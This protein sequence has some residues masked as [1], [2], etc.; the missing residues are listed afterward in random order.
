MR[1][2][3]VHGNDTKDNPRLSSAFKAVGMIGTKVADSIMASGTT[4]A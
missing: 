3:D 2:D 4:A 1:A